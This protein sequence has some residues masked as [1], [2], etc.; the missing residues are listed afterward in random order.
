MYGICNVASVKPV[1]KFC[2]PQPAFTC[3][4]STM[5]TPKQRVKIYSKLLIKTPERRQRHSN[6]SF[7]NF[8]QI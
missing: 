1:W 6:V 4:K 2:T 3:S 5:E 8:E 7:V